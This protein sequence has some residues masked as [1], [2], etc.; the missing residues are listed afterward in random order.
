MLVNTTVARPYAKAAFEQAQ[1]E[2]N[3]DM[4]S[5]LL[6]M[7]DRIVHDPQMRQLMNSPRISPRQML[8]LI[9]SIYGSNLSGSATNFI[10]ILIKSNR[11]KI[12][13]QI[14]T[15]FEQRR[16]LAEG[17]VEV[18]VVSAFELDAEQSKRIAEAMSKRTGKKVNISAVVDKSLIGGMIVRAGDSVIDASLRGRLTKLRNELIG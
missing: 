5:G 12:A 3:M 11:L 6:K 13:G 18:N 15:L 14:S 2:G 9:S 16:A 4:W 17:R 8:E 1:Q 10:K 7:L